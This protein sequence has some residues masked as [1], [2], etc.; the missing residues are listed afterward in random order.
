MV[1]KNKKGGFKVPVEINGFRKAPTRHSVN[2]KRVKP[3]KKGIMG[4]IGSTVEGL[5]EKGKK[6]DD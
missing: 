4:A 1:Q 2:F 5:E 6:N 3:T